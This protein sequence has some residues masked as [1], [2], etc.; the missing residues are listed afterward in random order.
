VLLL[1]HNNQPPYSA[2]TA[3]RADR[4]LMLVLVLVLLLLLVR[5]CRWYN[6]RLTLLMMVVAVVAAVMCIFTVI[7]STSIEKTTALFLFVIN[8]VA[9][10]IA[11]DKVPWVVDGAERVGEG[12]GG[13]PRLGEHEVQRHV[14]IL[15]HVN[16]PI[17][18]APTTA[19]TITTRDNLKETNEKR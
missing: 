11:K 9:V 13:A 6:G 5:R 17:P 3:T 19:T 4:G 15:C 2:A 1:F 18:K 8:T 10:V 16:V 14:E 7:A 12:G